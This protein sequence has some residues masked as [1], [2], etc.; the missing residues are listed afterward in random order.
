MSEAQQFRNY[1]QPKRAQAK[2]QPLIED[3]F[4]KQKPA[5]TD[6]EEEWRELVRRPHNNK[7]SKFV[8]MCLCT[9][10]VKMID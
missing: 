1:I 2:K 6:S 5:K 7:K 3:L 4:Q 8:K 9:H 10:N